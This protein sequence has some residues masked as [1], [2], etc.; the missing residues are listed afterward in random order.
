MP[1]EA[2]G[3]PAPRGDG[4]SIRIAAAGDIHCSEASREQTAAA[5]AEID[6]TVDL[7]LLAG[8]LTTQ[9]EPEQAAVLADACRNLETPVF[10]VL[11]NH[12]WQADRRDELVAVLEEG[13][14][15]VLD[16]G[17]AI[18]RPKELEVGIVGV[19]GFMG[20]F[21][22]SHVSNFGE[23]SM[24]ALYEE[25]TAEVAA[26]EEGLRAIET[27]PV[28]IVLLHYAPTAETL[29][30]EPE[31]IW[32]FLGTDRL[33][34]PIVEH[35]PDLVLHG[36]A[37]AGAFEGRV[38]GVPVFNVSVPVMRRDFWVFELTAAERRS[39]AIH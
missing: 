17:H 38:G 2:N 12:D 21:P 33:A 14:T 8:D 34:P 7:I 19:K 36:H 3:R 28:R 27:C 13:G 25:A 1:V 26:L 31:G 6:G 37:H 35:E 22:G 16:P 23:P 18:C 29:R 9:G 39:S 4:P 32:T 5:F 10:T 11:G 24:R 15:S 20:G 30:G